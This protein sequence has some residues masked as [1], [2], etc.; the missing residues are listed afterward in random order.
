[1][2]NFADYNGQI[3]E[4]IPLQDSLW[5]GDNIYCLERLINTTCFDAIFQSHAL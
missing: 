5:R 1:M 2:G 3:Q 4:F